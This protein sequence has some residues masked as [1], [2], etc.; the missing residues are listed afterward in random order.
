M[1]AKTSISPEVYQTANPETSPS[2]LLDD[3]HQSQNKHTNTSFTGRR[4]SIPAALFCPP[5]SKSS[6]SSSDPS[7]ANSSHGSSSSQQSSPLQSSK[8]HDQIPFSQASTSTEIKQP[9][10]HRVSTSK[11][12]FNSSSALSSVETL[13][14]SAYFS[15]LESQ[16]P[17]N[18]PKQPL[19]PSISCPVTLRNK[20]GLTSMHVSKADEGDFSSTFRIRTEASKE[21]APACDFCRRRKVRVSAPSVLNMQIDHL[22]V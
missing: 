20:V 12:V 7:S 9:Q 17:A 18:V 2:I 19:Q 5:A 15:P 16:I 6:Y 22:I 13:P 14:T 21:A 10:S 3:S 8:D 1:H 4:S 11:T